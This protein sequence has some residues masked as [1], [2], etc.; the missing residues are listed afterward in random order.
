MKEIPKI[1][2]FESKLEPYKETVSMCNTAL[3]DG[4]NR[5]DLSKYGYPLFNIIYFK[6][7]DTNNSLK[8]VPED[9]WNAYKDLRK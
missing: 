4:K 3:K 2:S 5:E 1:E 8:L 9:V 6:I 7:G